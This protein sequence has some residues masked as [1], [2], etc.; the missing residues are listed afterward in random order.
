M[1]AKHVLA[2]IM[3]CVC[4]IS[5]CHSDVR[6]HPVDNA[7]V[8]KV[9]GAVVSMR[10]GFKS[11][12]MTVTLPNGEKCRG[13]WRT[14]RLTK[15]HGAEAITE[16]D[17]A[18]DGTDAGLVVVAGNPGEPAPTRPSQAAATAQPP[19]DLES[20]WVAAW[21]RN[22]YE[23]Q[24]LEARSL[25]EATLTGNRGTVLHVEID[26]QGYGWGDVGGIDIMGVARDNKGNIYKV[27]A[28]FW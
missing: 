13:A 25:A 16:N 27:K 1:K 20:A 24:I 12:K 19:A 10:A 18:T 3:P 2:A 6:I 8:P 14:I 21:G 4:M 22:F 9:P 5:G 23:D 15:T 11:G 17:I 7:V 28:P 26:L